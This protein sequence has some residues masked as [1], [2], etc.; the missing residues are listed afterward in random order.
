MCC[1]PL[2]DANSSCTQHRK[3]HF[4]QQSG[5]TI[6]WIV[7]SKYRCLWVSL[8]MV[9]VFPVHGVVPEKA[10]CLLPRAGIE[11]LYETGNRLGWPI[12]AVWS[13]AAVTSLHWA[14][15]FD[16]KKKPILSFSISIFY[17]YFDWNSD[18]HQPVS[19]STFSTI[20]F[21]NVRLVM[22]NDGPTSTGQ[23]E[24]KNLS[25]R[26]GESPVKVKPLK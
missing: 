8:W 9:S 25:K 23:K 22:N 19:L 26:I 16:G 2:P 12:G 20:A 13:K 3:R 6:N 21:W 4:R 11:F 24:N 14:D 15:K 7:S 10:F 17:F 18:K 1:I 5:N